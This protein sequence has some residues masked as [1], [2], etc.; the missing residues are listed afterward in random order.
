MSSSCRMNCLCLCKLN[1]TWDYFRHDE[2][3]AGEESHEHEGEE[4]QI[5]GIMPSEIQTKQE[6]KDLAPAAEFDD[7][8]EKDAGNSPADVNLSDH[9]AFRDTSKPADPEVMQY[10][11]EVVAKKYEIFNLQ[12]I[13]RRNHTGFEETKDFPIRMNDCVAGRYQ[14]LFGSFYTSE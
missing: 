5:T 2:E 14:V 8:P 9:T 13:H 12:V 4:P 11:P 3:E 6:V 10:D 7:T 1:Y